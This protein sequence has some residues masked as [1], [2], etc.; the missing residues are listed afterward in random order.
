MSRIPT[1]MR[2][3]A[4]EE[5]TTL[6]SFIT[7]GDPDTAITLSAMD[8]LVK[9]GVDI[10]ELGI[11]F[12]D[13]EADG[14]SIQRASERALKSGTT[15]TD[16]LQ[17]VEKFRLQNRLTPVVLMGYLN[18]ILSM[19]IETF[20][21]RSREAGVDG[22]IVVNLPPEDAEAIRAALAYRQ[23][24]LI[25]LIAPTSSDARQRLIATKGSGFLYYVSLKGITGAKHID[26]EDVQSQVAKIKAHTDL[27]VV[28]G[29]GVRTPALAQAAGSVA[30]GVVVGSRFVEVVANT[31]DPDEIPSE[32]EREARKFRHSLD[33]VA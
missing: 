10:L 29:F 31:K 11:P 18:P 25:F 32:L 1:T 23:I 24:E 12:S 28:V 30:D 21:E 16:V 22:V 27:P 26:I 3:I 17:I 14:P 20:A 2:R 15:L 8:S 13:P 4:A 5:K 9:G 7:A 6:V 33:Q 19:G